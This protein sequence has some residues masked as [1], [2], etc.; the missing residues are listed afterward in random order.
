[1]TAV[2]VAAVVGALV[3]QRLGPGSEPVALAAAGAAAL[4]VH[5]FAAWWWPWARCWRPR[6][7]NGKIYRRG[8][9]VWRDCSWCEG[10]GK[11][12]RVGA[13]LV[14]KTRESRRDR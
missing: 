11:R 4:G 7:K 5:L 2:V 9:R 1:M 12:F 3:W 6:C 13:V 10:K 8:G 14:A